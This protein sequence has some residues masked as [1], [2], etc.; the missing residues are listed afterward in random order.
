LLQ[1][2]ADIVR[3]AEKEG[4]I[5]RKQVAEALGISIRTTSRDFST[6]LSLG[7]LVPDGRRGN[8]AGYMLPTMSVTI[9]GK[10]QTERILEDIRLHGRVVHSVAPRPQLSAPRAAGKETMKAR[11]KEIFHQVEETGRTTR[12]QVVQ[13]FGLSP[14]TASR[15]LAVLLSLGAL[16]PDGRRGRAAGYV[17]P[18]MTKSQ[19]M[20]IATP[21]LA[22]TGP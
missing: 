21:S 7:A 5:S 4:R 10:T 8:T 9:S 2:Q 12:K 20:P 14:R 6:L 13:C 19:P 16:V 1:R 22:S 3:L 17:L 15:E 18:T 11:Q